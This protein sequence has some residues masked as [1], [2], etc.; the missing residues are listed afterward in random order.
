MWRMMQYGRRRAQQ[1]TTV[2]GKYPDYIN[3]ADDLG[4][5]RFNVPTEV[6]NRMSKEEQWAA[7]KKF[8]DRMIARGDDIVLS[9]PV[10]DIDD[11]TGA[12]RRELDYLIEQG[13]R[14]GTDG[15]RMIR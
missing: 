12:L 9:N 13:F 15:T 11:V 6:W 5:K 3:L 10:F 1:G 8:L 14:L 7:N 4:A 2:L